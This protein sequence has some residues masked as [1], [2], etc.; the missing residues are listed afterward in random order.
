[1]VWAMWRVGSIAEMSKASWCSTLF[2]D[3]VYS[4]S[5]GADGI[6]VDMIKKLEEAGINNI[7]AL[8]K[9]MYVNSQM[10]SLRASWSRLRRSQ[11]QWNTVTIV[12]WISGEG[13]LKKLQLCVWFLRRI[14]NRNKM[15]LSVLR[16]MFE[17]L[18][19][20]DVNSHERMT[21]VAL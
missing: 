6:P 13:H 14:S 8:C 11:M 7:I 21:I 18:K 19:D 4:K 1:M 20:F 9:S 16:S 15:F 12:S 17:K 10:I 5:E 3:H 2:T